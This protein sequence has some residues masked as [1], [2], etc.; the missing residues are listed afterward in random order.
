MIKYAKVI[1]EDTKLCEVGIGTNE[2]FYKSIGMTQQDVEQCE[3]N[4]LW[5]LAG[6][7]PVQPEPSK[8]EKIAKLKQQLN[9]LDE[10]SSRSMRAILA[11][12]S[13]EDDRTFL[14]NLETQAESIRQQIRDLEEAQ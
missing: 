9:T 14:A 5:Y 13:T 2:A 12:T 8:E 4:S 3:W 7:C 11:N 6:H 10:K 1:N